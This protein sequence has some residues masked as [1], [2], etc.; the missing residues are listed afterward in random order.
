MAFTRAYSKIKGEEMIEASGPIR[1]LHQAWKD[2]NHQ[3]F[4]T[5]PD[6]MFLLAG[7]ELPPA[8]EFSY[9]TYDVRIRGVGLGLPV[10][11]NLLPKPE[12]RVNLLRGRY[13]DTELWD[14][15]MNRLDLKK[16]KLGGPMSYIFPFHRKNAPTGG[17]CLAHI[18]LTWYN[19]DWRVYVT[20]RASEIT[21]RLLGDMYFVD[22]CLHEILEKV[23]LKN[24][25]WDTLPL[26]WNIT[27]A[28][29]LKHMM[30]FYLQQQGE[31]RLLWRIVIGKVGPHNL[32][33]K[34]MIE[35]FWANII[36]PETVTWAQR[37]KYSEQFMKFTE[38][39]WEHEEQR[40]LKGPR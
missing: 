32:R 11:S 24:W 25:N 13:I 38:I 1:T 14:E 21:Y 22:S 40:Y 8:R 4:F 7:R 19:K 12:R 29:Q 26:C 3:F 36:H 28:S 34:G 9:M 33:V 37:R 10:T 23:P 39:D 6:E 5:W 16:K 18:I 35:Y 27:L 30:P 15:A 2:L 31:E 17:G 20:S